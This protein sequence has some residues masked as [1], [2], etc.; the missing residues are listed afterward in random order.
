M[1]DGLL[2]ASDQFLLTVTPVNDAPTISRITSQST[3]EDTPTNPIS[4]TI[5][6]IDT[7]LDSLTVSR[8]S[9]NQTLVPDSAISLGGSG[10]D[11]TLTITPA[12]N[13]SGTALI[14]VSVSEVL[15]NGYLRVIG[16]KQIG[17]N[18]EVERIR[19]SGVVNPVTILPGNVVPSTRVADA[20]VEYK[21][22]GAIDSATTMGWLSRFFLTVLPF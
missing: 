22:Q 5:G 8:S 7:A 10:A 11:R 13:Q 21:G 17:T 14:T 16:E 15:P 2:S 9:G 20:R 4:F 19:F 6:D 1:S 18:R 12:A 3:N